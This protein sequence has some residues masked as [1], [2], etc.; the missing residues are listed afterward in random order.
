MLKK[1]S[2]LD[3]IGAFLRSLPP[4]HKQV[5]LSMVRSKTNQ[6]LNKIRKQA[7]AEGQER[8]ELL[9]EAAMTLRTFIEAGI[10]LH[11]L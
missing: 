7:I 6:D 10:P 4:D 5:F 3:E 11:E 2:R 8:T 9:Y 1:L